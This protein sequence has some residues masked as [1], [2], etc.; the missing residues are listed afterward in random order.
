MGS[1]KLGTTLTA[2]CNNPWYRG[3]GVDLGGGRVVQLFCRSNQIRACGGGC[4]R[5][6]V[7]LRVWWGLCASTSRVLA[8]IG[9]RALLGRIWCC[10]GVLSP[11]GLLLL[12][13]CEWRQRTLRTWS[14]VR[15]YTI[16][17][18]Y[19]HGNPCVVGGQIVLVYF[20]TSPY[21]LNMRVGR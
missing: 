12:T 18:M 4:G 15:R 8:T 9:A 13:L 5:C 7:C 21:H 16:P 11:A 6:L 10:L 20:S 3:V 1:W 19:R 17:D 14:H 2:D